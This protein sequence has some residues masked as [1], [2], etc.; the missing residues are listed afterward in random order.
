MRRR[1]GDRR[2]GAVALEAGRERDA[3]EAGVPVAADHAPRRR[4]DDRRGI[5]RV[6]PHLLE[7]EEDARRKS[8][9]RFVAVG[10]ASIQRLYQDCTP[11]LYVGLGADAADGAVR[12]GRLQLRP[13]HDLRPRASEVA[14]HVCAVEHGSALAGR[15]GRGIADRLDVEDV[16]AAL[17]L[18]RVL[19]DRVDHVRVLARTV[20]GGESGAPDDGV[21]GEAVLARRR[22]AGV[23][24]RERAGRAGAGDVEPFRGDCTA[25]SPKF[26]AR[27]ARQ[28]TAARTLCPVA[29]TTTSVTTLAKKQPMSVV[30]P[31]HC[32]EVGRLT[33]T[34]DTA[35]SV[36]RKRPL[37]VA[38]YTVFPVASAGVE[39]D[40]GT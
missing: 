12:A 37:L 1:A 38:A 31:A 28:P 39:R 10:S 7:P 21:R 22:L 13:V 40:A 19:D 25:W 6:L 23:D 8:G 11:G 2:L 15:A 20:R 27:P 18:L 35:A 32:A 30:L 17:E 9:H 34:N 4:P 3:A 29:R 36:D 14:R 33:L 5:G 24:E 16:D 26:R